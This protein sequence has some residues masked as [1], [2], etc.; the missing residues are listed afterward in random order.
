M[1]Q[2]QKLWILNVTVVQVLLCVCAIAATSGNAENVRLKGCTAGLNNH[3]KTG[4]CG[5]K[6]MTKLKAKWI[7]KKQD[8]YNEYNKTIIARKSFQLGQVRKAVMRITA[9]SFYRL[10]INDR[11]V[12]DGP[13]RSWPE[14]Y[15]YDEIDVTSYLK[16]GRNKIRVIARYYGVGD[17][18]RVPQQAG[19]LVQLDAELYSGKIKTIISD[20]SWKV[21]EAKAWI[22]N[23]PKI[24]IQMEPAEYYDA[25]L[26]NAARFG[27]AAVLF[28]AD[29]GPWKD[30]NR[31]DVA[32][33]TKQPFSFKS[34]AGANIVRSDGLNFCIPVARLVHPGLIEANRNV[35]TPCG[36]ATI[37][38]A[39]QKCTIKLYLAGVKAA[40]DGKR[41]SSGE[42]NL[43]P[44]RHL[45]LV[46]V[47]YVCGHGKEKTIRFVNP[48]GFELENPLDG[49]NEN[50]WCFIRFDE[51]AFA[52]SD[53]HFGRL[54]NK[55]PGTK[56][57]LGHY[58]E[59]T[60]HLLQTVANKESFIE[61]LG[62]RSEQLAFDE[63]FVHENTWQFQYRQVVGDAAQMVENPS[64][65]MHDNDEITIVQPSKEGDVE[66]VYDLGEQNC[67]YY[68]IDL[69]ADEG[70]QMDICGIEFITADGKLQ[71]T[72]PNRNGVRYVT[73]QGVNRFISLKRRSGRYIFITLRNQKTPV[74]I[75]NVQLI[76]STYP[77][78]YI[79]SFSCSDARLDEIWEISTR[80]LKLCMEDTFTDCPLYEQTLWVGDA[81][82]ESL[83]AYT[84]FGATDIAA[85]CIK[86]AGQSLERYP[87]VGSQVPSGWECLLPAWSFLWGI[88]TWDY[89][90][91]TG[92]KEFLRQIWPWVIQ[93]LK[94]AEKFTDERGLFSGP[95]W[96]MFDW[97]K[98][99][100]GQ[101]TV[102]HNSMFVIGAID[103]A[104]KCGSVLGD[105]THTLWL[106]QFRSRLRRAVNKLWDA[107]KKAYPDSIR[108][109]G[110]ISPSICQHT[111]FLSIL[112]DI[113]EKENIKYAQR[114]MLEPPEEMVRIG[115][116]FAM[117][118][119]YETLE[120]IEL[121]DEII[122]SIYKAYLPMLEAGATTVWESF[123]AG[124]LR[125]GGFPTRSHCHGWSSA[126]VH[127]LNR[128]ILGI[129]QTS[130][131]GRTVQ[132]S[133][134]LNGLSWAKGSTATIR[135]PVSVA[136]RV[137]GNTLGVKYSAP[138]DVQVE[139]VR[140]ET[141]RDL[142][143]TVNGAA[144]D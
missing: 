112:Y 72:G 63:M 128:I 30:L 10:Y 130:A 6:E 29:R 42:Y 91:Y 47:S 116:P 122:K 53:L 25:R 41:N 44:G 133:P 76:E 66:L 19:L 143:V 39:R 141:H 4:Q 70:V 61:E 67:G 75:R 84:V 24:S 33:M 99:D 62:G 142:Q 64:G 135:G 144:F 100:Q 2:L 28:D 5:K 20:G 121:E 37:I 12:N 31:R 88:S 8:H 22:S 13:C 132:I 7:W 106:K 82:N 32:L 9:D 87:L 129:K 119:Q 23:T 57:D 79:G 77:V 95:F 17:F 46:F 114:N 60:D 14:H 139:F 38:K 138:K 56:V 3:L 117:L 98:I 125:R 27:K 131:G 45:L 15:Q 1:K 40:L 102:L 78:E 115:S 36:F 71:H 111:S 81:R 65:L 69:V 107:N 96:N 94:G 73:R 136:W 118:Y 85:R 18:H 26:E 34:F 48:A 74:R 108:A 54:R 58:A 120:K 103:A 51:F 109:D 93:N 104:L 101:K 137:E 113:I 59:M 80:T 89:Y 110:T 52:R 127:F 16:T 49:A 11:W 35:S 55:V 105:E 68:G 21:A 50:P 83:F 124:S 134:R 140:N 86:L 92:D 90:W 43:S 126:P 123:P 97:T